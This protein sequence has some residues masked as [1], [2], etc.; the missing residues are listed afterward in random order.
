MRQ[1]QH[2]AG[3]LLAV[4]AHCCAARRARDG[5]ELITRARGRR[6][7]LLGHGADAI[8]VKGQVAGTDRDP[9]P[10]FCPVDGCAL[11]RYT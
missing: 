11:S 5:E 1:E 9:V 7:W 8:A 6:G 10:A 2:L 4:G 3:T